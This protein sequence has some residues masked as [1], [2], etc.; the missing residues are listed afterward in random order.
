MK[1]AK[2][3]DYL[4][5]L[6]KLKRNFARDMADEC[7]SVVD[8]KYFQGRAEAFDEM[9]KEA[10]AAQSDLMV[11]KSAEVRAKQAFERDDKETV[12]THH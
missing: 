10:D 6:C 5:T 8:Q 9:A 7:D 3:L 12:R 2:V 11:P 1:L 4:A